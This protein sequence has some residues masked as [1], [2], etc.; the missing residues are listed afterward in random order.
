MFYTHVYIQRNQSIKKKKCNHSSRQWG[1]DHFITLICPARIDQFRLERESGYKDWHARPPSICSRVNFMYVASVISLYIVD[2]QSPRVSHL[3]WRLVKA[4]RQRSVQRP[5]HVPLYSTHSL[6]AAFQ[7]KQK[8][9]HA[10]KEC[11]NNNKTK[12]WTELNWTLPSVIQGHTSPPPP[13]CSFIY[14]FF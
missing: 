3:Y 12:G 14:F 7:G 9:T 5:F 2:S 10:H 4:P 13:L 6:V 11:N 8:H 1:V